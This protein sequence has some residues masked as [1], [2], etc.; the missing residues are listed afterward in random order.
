MRNRVARR[1]AAVL[2]V[3]GVAVLAWVAL[4]LAWGEP[5]TAVTAARAQAALREDLARRDEAPAPNARAFRRGLREGEAIGRIVV[6]R[7]GLR[8]VFVEGT[9]RR[10]LA[11]GPGHYGI[12]ALPGAGGTVAIAGHRTTYLQPFRHL[13]RLRPG[14][15]IVLELPYGTFRYVVYGRRIV[16]DQDW[17]IL[18]RRSFEKLVLTACHPLHSASQRIVVFARRGSSETR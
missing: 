7:L 6:P 8:T 2:A 15:R 9:S 10:D 13:D 3:A 4:T 16:D 12:T 14:D 11:R 1:A 5:F 17:S 18:R